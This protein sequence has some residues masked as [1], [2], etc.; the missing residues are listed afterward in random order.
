MKE[1]PALLHGSTT[2]IATP[3]GTCFVTVTHDDEGLLEVFV[4]VGKA[5]S[6]VT[7][8]AEG[9]GRLCS[10]ALRSGI[11]PHDIVDQLASIGRLYQ[12]DHVGAWSVPDAIAQALEKEIHDE[13]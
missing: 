12:A 3:A 7:A 4:N 11:A 13:D 5:G 1:R 6:Q 10:L 2:R 8:M 9:L